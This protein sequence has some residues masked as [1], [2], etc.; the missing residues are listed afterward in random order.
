MNDLDFTPAT[1]TTPHHH[2]FGKDWY[3][4]DRTYFLGRLW[5]K[6]KHYDIYAEKPDGMRWIP[7]T[8]MVYER[9]VGEDAQWTYGKAL[10][11]TDPYYPPIMFIEKYITDNW[12]T[13]LTQ[14]HTVS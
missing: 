14:G 4:R 9:G 1:E 3:Y 12:W 13:I 11:N 8:Y 7:D 10:S 5:W 6:Q 2:R